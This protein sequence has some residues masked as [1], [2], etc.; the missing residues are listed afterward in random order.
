MLGYAVSSYM[1]LF[2][3]GH[4][5]PIVHAAMILHG[6]SYLLKRRRRRASIH[7]FAASSQPPSITCFHLSNFYRS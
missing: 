1:G 4:H 7:E 6:T 3:L 2:D 5:H